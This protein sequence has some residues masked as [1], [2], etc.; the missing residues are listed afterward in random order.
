MSLVVQ[1]KLVSRNYHMLLDHCTDAQRNGI[2]LQ[3]VCWGTI[4]RAEGYDGKDGPVLVAPDGLS[5][6]YFAR[7][8]A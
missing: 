7:R 3:W 2:T 1:G 6:R 8:S 5:S 4:P